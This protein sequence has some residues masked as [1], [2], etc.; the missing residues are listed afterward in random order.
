MLLAS[1]DT[2]PRMFFIERARNPN[3]PWSGQIAFPG[4][5][6][7][8]E[9]ADTFGTACRETFEEVGIVLRE[10]MLAN[11]LDDQ[12]GRAGTPSPLVVSCYAC[13]LDPVQPARCGAEVQGAFWVGIA[14]LLDPANR[15]EYRFAGTSHPAI[16]LGS[17]RVLWGLTY[18][19]V[20]M[21]LE[22][23]D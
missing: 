11:R 18:R 2:R 9:D 16:C 14:H 22:K 15:M 20:R 13:I 1:L 17:D 3:D 10:D 23:F 12:L 6:L 21:L 8:P 7:E 5:N 19:F 4:G